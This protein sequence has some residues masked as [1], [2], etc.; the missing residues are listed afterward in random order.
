MRKIRIG[1]RGSR[2]A[3]WQTD[4]VIQKML[5]MDRSLEIEKVLIKTKGDILLDVA[6]SKIGDKGLFTKEIEKEI[7]SGSIDMAVH[8]M[9]DMPTK[10]T[11]GL[12]LGAVLQ[13]E[14][15]KDVLWPGTECVLA[16][17]RQVPQ[18]VRPACGDGVQLLS[19]RPDL[20]IVELRV[21]SIPGSGV[22]LTRR[23]T[24]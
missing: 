6:L 9:K 23:W 19:L 20:N 13:R 2:L 18:L 21:T 22:C 17:R 7:L 1:S 3:L 12:A 8:S 5:A 4:F 10:I 16:Q 14:N 11:E 24:P 15:P